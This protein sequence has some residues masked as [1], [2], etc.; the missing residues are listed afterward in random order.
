MQHITGIFRHEMQIS[1]LEEAINPDHQ[2][3]FIDAL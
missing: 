1:S 2:V 3:R